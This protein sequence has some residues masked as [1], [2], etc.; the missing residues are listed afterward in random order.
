MP[1]F[2][3]VLPSLTTVARHAFDTQNPQAEDMDMGELTREEVTARLEAV[4]ARI[5]A[6]AQAT[7]SKIEAL[8]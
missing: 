3:R 4:E 7:D 5:D 6:R 1:G 8:E 2:A